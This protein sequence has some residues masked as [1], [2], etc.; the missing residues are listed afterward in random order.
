MGIQWWCLFSH[1]TMEIY[2]FTTCAYD[3]Y[4][5]FQCEFDG[6][7]DYVIMRVSVNTPHDMAIIWP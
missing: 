1:Q 4:I 7:C 2:Q 3:L 5:V 6:Y